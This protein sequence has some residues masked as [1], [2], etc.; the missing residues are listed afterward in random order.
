ME[1]GISALVPLRLR[2]EPAL[3]LSNGACLVPMSQNER[4]NPIWICPRRDRGDR[5][6]RE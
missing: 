2:S 3:S 6:E 4:T 1:N 5:R